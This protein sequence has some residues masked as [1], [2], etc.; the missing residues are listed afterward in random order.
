[1]NICWYRILSTALV[2]SQWFLNLQPNSSA[3]K[4]W[5]GRRFKNHWHREFSRTR[6]IAW[7]IIIQILTHMSVNQTDQEI[8]TTCYIVDNLMNGLVVLINYP[9]EYS[10]IKTYAFLL[11]FTP[12]FHH[13]GLYSPRKLTQFCMIKGYWTGLTL[14]VNTGSGFQ[15]LHCW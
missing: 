6:V 7:L 4:T 9:W 1:M 8:I 2:W 13:L 12:Q 11:V 10:I 3:A 15:Y 14:L 5:F